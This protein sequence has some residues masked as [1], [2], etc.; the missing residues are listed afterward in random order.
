MTMEIDEAKRLLEEALEDL[1]KPIVRPV[2]IQKNIKATLAMLDK[3]QFPK[4]SCRNC[5]DGPC[6][7]NGPWP[8]SCAHNPHY[9][10]K[11]RENQ[12]PPAEDPSDKL[13]T[14]A[15]L[16][17][18]EDK[19]HI[20]GYAVGVNF[21]ILLIP[22]EELE[23]GCENCCFKRRPEGPYVCVDCHGLSNWKPEKEENPHTKPLYYIDGDG[24][25]QL[26]SEQSSV[27]KSDKGEE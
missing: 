11:W 23:K 8:H 27:E 12:K 26:S 5:G 14:T 15:E 25:A 7:Y 6:F 3:I 1:N 13:R 2:R 22:T 9:E 4:W 10:S 17:A 18:L 16:K 24:E 20:E 21:A 19:G